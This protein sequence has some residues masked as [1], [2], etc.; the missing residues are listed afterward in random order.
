MKICRFD[1]NR[2][3]A[4][5]GET[6]YDVTDAAEVLPPCHWPFP[7]GDLAMSRLPELVAAIEARGMSGV[8][9]NIGDVAL[10][11]P[12]ANPAK[13]IGAPINYEA[14]RAEAGQDPGLHH[15]TH[16]TDF[17][18]FATPIAKYGLFL[19]AATSVAGAGQGVEVMFPERRTDH[20]VE[21]AV[22]IGRQAKNVSAAGALDFVAGYCIGLDMSVRGTEARSFRKSPDGYTVLGPWLTTADEIADPGNLDLQI[23][24]NGEIKQQS[25][26]SLLTVSVPELIAL[27]S[28][29][30]TLYPGDVIMTGTPEGV[31]PVGAGDVM[32][33]GIEGLGSMRVEVR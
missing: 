28:R 19:K 7:P 6:V 2:L 20:E 26:T 29:W 30:Y 10:L 31:G 25:N 1:D 32:E 15:G 22:V 23:T 9:H 8:K 13:I 27:A 18:G 4:V 3:G 5:I 17:T 11:S 21:L 14:H 33:A 24:V 16:Q 12:I